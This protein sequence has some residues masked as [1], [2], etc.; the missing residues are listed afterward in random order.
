MTN[1]YIDKINKIPESNTKKKSYPFGDWILIASTF[2][3][4]WLIIFPVV[5]KY[6]ARP[7]ISKCIE[8]DTDAQNTLAALASYFSETDSDGVPTLQDLINS[9]D[10]VLNENSTVIIDGPKDTMRVTVFDDKN[11]CVRGYR[12]EVYMGGTSGEWYCE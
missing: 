4:A 10:L 2:F 3:C 8:F 9:E 12:Y 6:V 5:M 1:P 11:R 7:S